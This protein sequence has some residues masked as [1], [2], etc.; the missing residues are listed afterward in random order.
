MAC[1]KMLSAYLFGETEE[2][3]R[4]PQIRI[5]SNLVTLRIK[6]V[7]FNTSPCVALL[8]NAVKVSV[9][10]QE[11]K[12]GEEAMTLHTDCYIPSINLLLISI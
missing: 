5:T 12:A 9:P 10:P 4:H 1:L 7:A 3:N 2:D 8:I 6:F 11:R